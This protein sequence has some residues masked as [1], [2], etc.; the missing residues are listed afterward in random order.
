MSPVCGIVAN[1][2]GDTSR[3]TGFYGRFS[4]MYARLKYTIVCYRRRSGNDRKKGGSVSHTSKSKMFTHSPSTL[5]SLVRLRPAST[6]LGRRR[7]GTVYR[8]YVSCLGRYGGLNRMSRSSVYD[9]MRVLSCYHRGLGDLR[10]GILGM[11][12]RRT[13]SQIHIQST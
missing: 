4:G 13:M 7:G 12:I 11:G 5:L 1:S 8:M 9:D 2:R 6:L 3:V 10:F